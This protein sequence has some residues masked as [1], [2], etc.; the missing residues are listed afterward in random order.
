MPSRSLNDMNHSKTSGGS[1]GS[2]TAV[3]FISGTRASHQAPHSQEPRWGM[4]RIGPS[5]DRAARST[6]SYPS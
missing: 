2:T 4:T 1:S 5:P 3:T 6:G